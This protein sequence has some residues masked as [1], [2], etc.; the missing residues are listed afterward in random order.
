MSRLNLDL[1]KKHLRTDDI[2]GEDEYL[3]FLLDTGEATIIRCT[4][5]SKED[6]LEMG[7]G[8]F[9]P[10]LIHAILLLCGTWYANRESVSTVQMHE[11]PASVGALVKPF[12]KLAD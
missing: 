2:D 6:L 1:L 10:M 5:R 4:N 9:P 3:Q 12:R 7:D 11:I 8:D